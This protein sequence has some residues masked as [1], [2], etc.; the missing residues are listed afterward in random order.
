MARHT[1]SHTK[2]KVTNYNNNDKKGRERKS[3]EK[4]TYPTA[5]LTFAQFHAIRFE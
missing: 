1:E 5:M 4:K 3:E 2:D